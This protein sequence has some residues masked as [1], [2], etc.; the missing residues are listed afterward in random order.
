M[1]ILGKAT[2][3][4]PE[5]NN[6]SKIV[7]NKEADFG[8]LVNAANNIDFHALTNITKSVSSGANMNQSN[9][10]DFICKDGVGCDAKI[11]GLTV[12]DSI[13]VSGSVNIA[14]I[15]GK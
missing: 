8:S 6:H 12:G 9:I 10:K 14:N 2:W 3:K 13:V 4:N 5:L 11:S 7:F 1:K 15:T